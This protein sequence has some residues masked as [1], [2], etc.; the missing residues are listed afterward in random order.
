MALFFRDFS[1]KLDVTWEELVNDVNHTHT[2]NPYFKSNSYYDTFKY[3]IVSILH[4]KEIVLLD[5]DFSNEEV[6]KLTSL[7]QLT[8]LDEPLSPLKEEIKNP[9][10]LLMQLK[11]N[12]K[13]WGITLF[14]SGTTGTPKKVRHSFTSITRNVKVTD[15]TKNNV[16]GFAYNP[17]HMAGIQVFF[18]ALLNQNT[19][20][21]LFGS[22]K[23]RIFSEINGSKITHI[24]ATPS[25]YRLL[26]PHENSYESVIRLTSGGEKFSAQVFDKLTGVF[27]NAKITNVYASTEAG[28][29]FG[30]SKDVFTVKEQHIGLVKIVEEELLIHTSLV[31][32]LGKDD[33]E[34][35]KTGDN[36]EIISNNPLQFKILSRKNEMINVGGYKVNP[37]EVEEVIQGID[38]ITNAR[39]FAKK[40]SVLGNII[41]AEIV[42]QKDIT[43]A[44]IRAYLQDKL[45]EYKIP[46]II[47]FVDSLSITRT[48]K[49]KR[50]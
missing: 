19:I 30:S 1:Q 15:R 44:E 22:S 26:L 23:D 46:R 8:D 29:L 42:A 37:T 47:R 25:F 14:T 39:V 12:P 2:F 18:Q 13:N 9:D 32:Q 36:V 50:S 41:C 40:N 34:W 33:E 45:Q 43:E 20:I 5:A 38:T 11:E 4:D 16:W 3:I 31:G 35:Y 6:E 48:G 21:R 24:S 10:H 27:P 7:T 17:T 49:I 28:A